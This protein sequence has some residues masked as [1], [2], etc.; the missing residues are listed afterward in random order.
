MKNS[1]SRCQMHKVIRITYKDKSIRK[2][3]CV[4]CPYY[5][6][7][8]HERD[9]I[10]NVYLCNWCDQPFT[11][12]SY[13]IRIAKPLCPKC[14]VKTGRRGRVS[15]Q[16]RIERL[17]TLEPALQVSSINPL[18]NLLKEIGVKK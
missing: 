4:R 11:M 18:D 6:W 13:S 8:R 2:Y 14:R 5:I 3:K 9:T 7:V 16:T 12:D 1:P 10:G 17:G 15:I